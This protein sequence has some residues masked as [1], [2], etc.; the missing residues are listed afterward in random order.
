MSNGIHHVTAIGGP[1]ARNHDFYTRVLGM[2]LVKTTVNFDDPGTYHLY[3]G[4]E[5]GRPGT[6]LTF[7]PWEHVAA[8]RLG[9]GETQETVF[10]VPEAA[11]G[12]WAHRFIEKGVD[13]QAP[14]KRFGE[15]VCSFKDPDGTR[16]ALV[17]VPGA[18][19]EP[20]WSDGTIPAEHALRGMQGVSLLLEE[21]G[22][23]GAILTDIFGFRESGKEDSTTRYVLP[24]T[25]VGGVVDIRAVGGFL[26][27]RVGGG[28]VH[29]VAFRARDD[30]EQAE[31]VKRLKEN[32][33]IETT[34][35]KDRNY[36][37]S[38]YF[39]EPG[40]IL[41]EIAT[42]APGFSVDEPADGLGTS[43]KLPAQFEP[44]RERIE[45]ALPDLGRE[46]AP[47]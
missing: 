29:H 46:P 2:R 45:R 44:M 17:A 14:E 42:D 27:P 1:A 13:H 26:K 6:I 33:G 41:F 22:A 15:T 31:M 47:Q 43:L 16:L 19:A 10:R 30:A 36:F 35:Q 5:A 24:G 7:F 37:R 40:H 20:G 28:S 11:M 4:D 12:F 32:H 21:A 25:P 39:R 3:Y 18:E 8:G 38:V 23:T 34:E 9:V